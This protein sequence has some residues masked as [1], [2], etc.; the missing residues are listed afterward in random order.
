MYSTVEIDPLL[1]GQ[2]YAGP[3]QSGENR[4]WVYGNRMSHG[5]RYGMKEYSE[6]I[7]GQTGVDVGPLG[8]NQYSLDGKPDVYGDGLP[9]RW[10]LPSIPVNW[11]K[12]QARDHYDVEKQN[13]TVYEPNL[14]GLST[15]DHDP[16]FG[17]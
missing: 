3:R 10:G 12:P 17:G 8:L 5:T 16:L 4:A 13:P 6:G 7:P 1:A 14:I 2:L 11:Y 15:P 9:E